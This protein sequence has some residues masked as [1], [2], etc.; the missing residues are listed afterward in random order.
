ML[1]SFVL[2]GVCIIE[3][4]SGLPLHIRGNVVGGTPDISRAQFSKLLKLVC[5]LVHKSISIL[6]L[7]RDRGL[8]GLSSGLI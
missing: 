3:R 7:Y 1:T 2:F 4:L 8:V 5:A 6:Q